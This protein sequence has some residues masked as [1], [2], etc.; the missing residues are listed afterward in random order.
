[1][2]EHA[3]TSGEIARH[4][5]STPH[6]S[7]TRTVT[8]VNARFGVILLDNGA[9]EQARYTGRQILRRATMHFTMAA[10]ARRTHPASF[11]WRERFATIA[12]GCAACTT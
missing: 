11:L 2:A 6:N 1:M 4:L 7:P 10:I 3:S 12:L 5:I 8:S 9:I